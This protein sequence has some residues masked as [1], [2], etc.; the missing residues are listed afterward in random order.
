VLNNLTLE[1]DG[2][3]SQYLTFTPNAINGLAF[4]QSKSFNIRI[5]APAYLSKREYELVFYIKGQAVSEQSYTNGEGQAHVVTTVKDFVEKR[6][7]TLVLHEVG[8]Q[9]AL[10]ARLDAMDAVDQMSKAGF[11]IEKTTA[12]LGELQKAF[13]D[14]DFEKTQELSKL[15][16]QLKQSAFDARAAIMNLQK[17]VADAEASG[18][19]MTETKRLLALAESA[20]ARED[21][22]TAQQRASDA[23][24]VQLLQTI[25]AFN[26]LV[27]V[28]R[29]WWQLVLVFLAFIGILVF[30]YKK[31]ELERVSRKLRDLL[32]EEIKIDELILEAQENCFD[33]RLISL[34]EY[35]HELARLENRRQEI[36]R[37]RGILLTRKLALTS[38]ES[39]LAQLREERKRIEELMKSL[40]ERYFHKTELGPFDYA[41]QLEGYRKM[42]N[43]ADE[44]IAFAEA[45]IA[46]RKAGVKGVRSKIGMFID[47]ILDFLG[48]RK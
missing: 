25:G 44:G 38:P 2:Y 48:V 42:L 37:M 34:E 15:I 36:E 17:K 20:L 41:Q 8:E 23:A 28:Q 29:N 11:K 32:R 18:I 27:F 43:E 46:A 31:T 10:T 1:T 7:V 5:V 30:V 3:L 6:V 12:L 16:L 35:K 21:Y 40:Q 13:E 24:N 22:I 9:E 4:N 19:N 14:G 39:S 47:W 33:K 45:K 26:T